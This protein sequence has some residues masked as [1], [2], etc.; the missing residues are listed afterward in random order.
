MRQSSTR[1]V[2]LSALLILSTVLHGFTPAPSWAQSLKKRTQLTVVDVKGKRVGRVFGLTGSFLVRRSF[3]TFPAPA[4]V[5]VAFQ[6]TGHSPFVVGV[7]SDRFIGNFPRNRT[8]G[9]HE[10]VAAAI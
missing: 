7:V 4:G 2:F 6:V 3:G 10:I 5:L 9:V 8:D 1:A